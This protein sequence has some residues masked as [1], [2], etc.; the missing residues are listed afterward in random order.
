MGL[1]VTTTTNI[2][3]A[4]RLLARTRWIQAAARSLLLLQVLAGSFGSANASPYLQLEAGVSTAERFRFL[5]V[6][7]GQAQVEMLTPCSRE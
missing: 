3:R 5:E 6:L 2:R 7:C 1:A 4:N